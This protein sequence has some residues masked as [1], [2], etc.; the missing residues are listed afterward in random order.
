MRKPIL[1]RHAS[2]RAGF[3]E[4]CYEN[5]KTKILRICLV[6][7]CICQDWYITRNVKSEDSKRRLISAGCGEISDRKRC[8][9]MLISRPDATPDSKSKVARESRQSRYEGPH[10]KITIDS[11]SGR[12]EGRYLNCEVKRSC[13][14]KRRACLKNLQSRRFIIHV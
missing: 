1:I 2:N 5:N 7:I 11:Q 10:A 3:A 13:G 6:W 9:S 4:G 12:H 14:G 8:A